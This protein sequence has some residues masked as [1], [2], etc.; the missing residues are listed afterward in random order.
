MHKERSGTLS[1]LIL[2][3]I[4]T[5][6]LAGCGLDLLLR[7]DPAEPAGP[8]QVLFIGNS[9]TAYGACVEHFESL[10]AAAGIEVITGYAVQG[11][12]S[13]TDHL[14]GFGTRHM[15]EERQW[16]Y[17]VL[18]EGSYLIAFPDSIDTVARPFEAWQEIIRDNWQKTR[19]VLFMGWAMDPMPEGWPGFS[20]FSQMLHD[21]T[22][23][24]ANRLKC[25]VAPI[26]WMWKQV[27]EERPEI[28]LLSDP[29]HPNTTGGYLQACIYF[30][31]IL[32]KSPFGNDYIGQL[33]EEIAGYIQQTA[34]DV[35]LKHRSRWRL[36]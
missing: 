1:H 4:M 20:E 14:E 26:G 8:V 19:I 28:T 23:L 31:A 36:P 11:G 22:L 10:A 21:G 27:V 7:E 15:I 35:V 25:M 2:L 16:N 32:Q 9:L 6:V 29:I 34:A 18:Q 3:F 24:L 12:V 17:I 30:A 5:G 13:L 33:D